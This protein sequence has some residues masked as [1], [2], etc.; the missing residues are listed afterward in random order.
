MSDNGS[1]LTREECINISEGLARVRDNKTLYKR[2]LGMFLD[3][4]E[5]TALQAY[6]AEKDYEK[7][8]ESAH[9]IKGMTGNLALTA[10]F[11]T[12]A[13]LMD[14]LREGAAS[15]EAETEFEAAYKQTKVYVAEVIQ[16][17]DA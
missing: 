14:E 5:L 7:A 2:M 4:D 11:T 15:A 8:G 12:S 16:E 13:R 6:L 17:L 10:L 3:S 9:A 1:T